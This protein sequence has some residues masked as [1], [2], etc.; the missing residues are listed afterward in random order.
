MAEPPPPKRVEV[1]AGAALL[2][3]APK[4]GLTGAALVAGTGLPNR[5][6]ALDVV[7]FAAEPKMLLAPLVLVD[8][9]GFGLAFALDDGVPK[10]KAGLSLPDMIGGEDVL[11]RCV[12]S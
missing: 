4:R 7:G 12:C 3:T 11:T 5:P 1:A 6:G 10:E 2:V 8:A 9:K